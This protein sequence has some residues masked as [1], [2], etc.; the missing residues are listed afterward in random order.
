LFR[1]E[2]RKAFTQ[3]ARGEPAAKRGEMVVLKVS[4]RREWVSVMSGG[5]VRVC[6]RFYGVIEGM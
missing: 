2:V 5:F 4:R 6:G 1:V 3:C